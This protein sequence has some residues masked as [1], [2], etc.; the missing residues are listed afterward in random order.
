MPPN[1]T[2]RRTLLAVMV[3]ACNDRRHTVSLIASENAFRRSMPLLMDFYPP[4]ALQRTHF[5]MSPIHFCAR[6]G[7]VASIERI[8]YHYPEEATARNEGNRTPFHFAAALNQPAAIRALLTAAPQGPS[9]RDN[10]GWLP[11][12]YIATF[13]PPTAELRMLL[14]GVGGEAAATMTTSNQ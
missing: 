10:V 2:R 11:S 5:G 3:S 13:V 14:G 8:L 12:A 7:D 9:L 4:C 6:R 1:R